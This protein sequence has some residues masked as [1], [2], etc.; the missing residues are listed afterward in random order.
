M[1]KKLSSALGVDI[2]SKTIKVAEV[3]NQG[4]QAVVTALG[5]IETPADSVDHTGVFNPDAVGAALKQLL[6]SIGASSNNVVVSI[7]GQASVLVRTLEVPRMNDAEL[8]EHM[9]WEISRNIPFAESTVQS[10]YA[11]LDDVD[12]N[13]ANMDVVLAISPQSAV[14]TIISL[15]KKAGKQLVAIDV[16]PTAVARTLAVSGAD[17]TAVCCVVDIGHKTTGINIYRG[18]NLVMPRQVPVGG[19]LFAQ[20]LSRNLNL[21][22]EEAEELLRSRAEIPSGFMVEAPADPFA[23][24]AAIEPE[25][26]Q[27]YNPFAPEA[28]PEPFPT[29]AGGIAQPE[30]TAMPSAAPE[31][32]GD[33]ETMRLLDGFRPALDELV[34]EVRR[35]LDYFRSKGGEVD[36]LLLCGGGSHLRGLPDFMG[37][38]LG[39]PC[40]ILDPTKGVQVNARKASPEL[41]DGRRTEFVIAIGNGLHIL[42]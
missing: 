11:K 2:G 31:P 1:A 32:V 13:A 6:S 18:R 4:R 19:E 27:P 29:E 8:A 38:A 25:P 10:A 30:E 7:A 17:P 20:E 12:P 40:E 15:V 24:P 3:R 22:Y 16:E 35:S 34:A 23:V 26:L 42:F 33:S 36:R 41:L 37:R 28:S 39:L 9:Q 14:D 21:G 5:V